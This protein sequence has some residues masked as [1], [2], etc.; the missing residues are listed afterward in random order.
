M[1]I[2]GWLQG[3]GVA[4]ERRNGIETAK[5]LWVAECPLATAG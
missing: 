3:V 4:I 2:N 1:I 5:S